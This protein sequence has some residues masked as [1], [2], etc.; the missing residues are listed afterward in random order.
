VELVKKKTMSTGFNE[1]TLACSAQD[2]KGD[3]IME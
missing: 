1:Q 2:Q 3:K